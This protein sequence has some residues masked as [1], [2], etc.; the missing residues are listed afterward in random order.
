M[1]APGFPPAGLGRRWVAGAI[2]SLV[3]T[4]AWG[5][6][7]AWL[8]LGVWWLRGLP[9]NSRELLVMLIALAVLGVLLRLLLQ[10]TFVGGCGQTLGYMML[11]IGVVD[12]AGEVPGYG[13]AL[14]RWLGGLLSALSLGLL[15]LPFLF[16]RD[17]R[18]VADRLGGTRVVLL[19]PRPASGRRVG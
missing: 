12:A 18:G 7:A 8:I 10:V 6:G 1:T 5:V 2:D 13:R 14:L 11:G 3:G 9:R 16:T 15:S 17:R 4:A 19:T